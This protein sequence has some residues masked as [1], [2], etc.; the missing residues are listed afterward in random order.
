MVQLLIS[1]PLVSEVERVLMDKFAWEQRRIRRIC[2][3]LWQAARIV[4]PITEVS[5]CRDRK[6]NHLLALAVDGQA[7]YLIT[8]DNDLLVLSLF[9]DIPIVTPV[10]FIDEK[11]WAAQR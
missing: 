4:K 7:D 2:Q 5:A 3:P 8:G 11:L 1:P 6:D 9:R 10:R